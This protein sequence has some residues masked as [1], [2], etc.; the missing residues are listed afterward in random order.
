MTNIPEHETI[1]KYP[2]SM[3]SVQDVIMPIGA[4]II[5]LDIQ[6]DV[7]TLWVVA[8][9]E[10]EDEKRTFTMYGTGDLLDV[11]MKEEH[12][13]TFLQEGGA[14]VWHVFERGVN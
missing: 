7:L 6:S 8:N 13:G 4:T 5:H 1:L 3:T 10:A 12:V 9:A 11:S 14:F 2:L